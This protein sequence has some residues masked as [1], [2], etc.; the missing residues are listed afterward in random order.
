MEKTPTWWL[1]IS[2]THLGEE[3]ME[4]TSPDFQLAVNNSIYTWQESH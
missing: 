2:G 1:T 3:K 4:P